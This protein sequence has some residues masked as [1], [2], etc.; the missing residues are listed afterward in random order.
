MEARI[1]S[2][3]AKTQAVFAHAQSIF[4]PVVLQQFEEI[5][6]RRIK[7]IVKVLLK[8]NHRTE[9]AMFFAELCD[10]QG[11]LKPVF[12]LAE[13]RVR[14]GIFLRFVISRLELKA[15]FH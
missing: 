14:S 10:V 12:H 15:V 4:P 2:S 3:T 7:N 6:V 9:Y 11:N 8:P 5:I 1:S 13:F